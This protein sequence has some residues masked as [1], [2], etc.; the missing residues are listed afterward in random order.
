L[1]GAIVGEARRLGVR[2]LY[3]EASITALPFF[4]SQRFDVLAPQVVVS[5]GVEFRNYRIARNL[6]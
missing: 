2:R 5:R 3:A 4:T 1:L 6:A